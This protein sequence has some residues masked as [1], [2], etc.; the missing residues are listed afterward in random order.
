MQ[1]PKFEE[2]SRIAKDTEAAAASCSSPPC[3]CSDCACSTAAAALLLIHTL[4][5]HV[6]LPIQLSSPSMLWL[7]TF[8]SCLSSP[9]CQRSESAR[10][11]AA[12]V[13]LPVDALIAHVWQPSQLTSS[14]T[15]W[16]RT[17]C[18]P[19]YGS[20]TCYITSQLRPGGPLTGLPS[21]GVYTCM[22]LRMYIHGCIC[23]R[24]CKWDWVSYMDNEGLQ[25]WK[26]GTG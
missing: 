21:V 26:K 10:P 25:R 14:S 8:C 16:L 11:T 9:P 24:V 15:L 7:R 2:T 5:A 13:L 3:R 17:F 12:E 22:Y 23:M 18:N 6:L 19:S 1:K 20:V 4:I